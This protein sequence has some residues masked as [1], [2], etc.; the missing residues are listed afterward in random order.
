MV[1]PNC[2]YEIPDGQ[3]LCEKCG[4]E[5][6]IVPDFEPEIESNIA[7]HL[8]NIVDEIGEK[9]DKEPKTDNKVVE[10]TTEKK[11]LSK[12]EKYEKDFF[13][14]GD[15]ILN[16][17]V[18]KTAIIVL[19]L[20]GALFIGLVVFVSVLLY[21]NYSVNYQLN[22]AVKDARNHDMASAEAHIAKAYSL[23]PGSTDVY[24]YEASV[25]ELSGNTDRAISFL[26]DILTNKRLD[27]DTELVLYKKAV[28]LLTS[29]GDYQ[30]ISEHLKF[31]PEHIKKEFV[32]YTAF[33]PVFT[34]PTGNYDEATL[35][36]TSDSLGRIY[37]T[38][39]G[40][41]P[42]ESN[43]FLYSSPV[44]L[45]PG[46][47]DLRAV[48]INEYGA[49]SDE[50]AACYLVDVIIPDPPKISP[51]SGQYSDP[52]SIEIEVP[53]DFAVYYT[54]D[55][56]DPDP[57]LSDTLLYETPI[58]VPIGLS[59]YSFVCVSKE[60]IVSE[61]VQRS[62]NIDIGAKIDSNIGHAQLLVS[63][64]EIGYISDLDGNVADKSASFSYDY[65]DMIKI[66][67]GGYFYRYDEF[68]CPA[69]GT[70]KPTGFLYAVNVKTAEVSRLVVLE[71]G[72]WGLFPLK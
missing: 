16:K 68:L 58:V 50:S 66:A 22:Q 33:E 34:L 29:S 26:W 4:Q 12:S 18:S 36:L 5:I 35:E 17:K 53:E 10:K 44:E 40:T 14:D 28:S 67:D 60:G 23:A 38:V 56:S 70:K 27:E 49:I 59:N 25:Y 37:Y 48:L 62:Y 61:P 15:N 71:D 11:N 9:K 6:N 55:G 41:H 72:N 52:F 47:Y 20:F 64:L 30:M 19:S 54:T 51:E 42:D 13:G 8:S 1:C 21:R 45:S 63:L 46:E 3:L 32:T 57:E 24:L 39:D 43:G 7:E 31:A 2:G 65:H 69:G